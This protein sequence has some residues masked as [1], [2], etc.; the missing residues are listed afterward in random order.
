MQH[1]IVSE[2]ARNKAV[3][4]GLLTGLDQEAYLWKVQ[5]D[6]WCLLEIIC[7][8]YDE[9]REDFRARVRLVLESPEEHHPSIDPQAWVKSRKYIEQDFQS[10][11][12]SFLKEREIS[13]AWLESLEDPK[14]HNTY[15]HPKVGPLTAGFFLSNWLAHDYLHIRQITRLKY[16]YLG[17]TSGNVLDYAGNWI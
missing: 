17:H 15:N 16:D 1:K 14:W 6:K 12:E 4:E 9:E 11:L 10:K 2:L 7:H 3:F 8:L 13:V 5:P